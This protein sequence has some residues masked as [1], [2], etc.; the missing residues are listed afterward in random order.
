MV[1]DENSAVRRVNRGIAD[2]VIVMEAGCV[3]RTFRDV[4]QIPV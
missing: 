4:L 3:S 1:D 2:E